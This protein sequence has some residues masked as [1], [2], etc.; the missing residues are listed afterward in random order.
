M[1]INYKWLTFNCVTLF[2]MAFLIQFYDAA[3]LI[4][5]MDK[6]H[7]TLAVLAIYATCSAY[8]GIMGDKA[9]FAAVS[10][11]CS[12]L[13]GLALAGT[14]VAIYMM[15]DGAR[16]LE[17]FRANFVGELAPVFLTSL[18]GIAGNWLMDM[19]IGLCFGK[20]EKE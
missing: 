5:V 20:Y 9:N 18:F 3:N 6:T 14:L 11:Y 19:Q 10:Y 16:D 13:T 15:M 12:R 8:L 17:V 7:V 4:W 1:T 2:I